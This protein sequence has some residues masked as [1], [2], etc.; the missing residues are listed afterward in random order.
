MARKIKDVDVSGSVSFRETPSTS[1]S[2]KGSGDFS[3]P[4]STQSGSTTPAFSEK[5]KVSETMRKANSNYWTPKQDA[6]K[7]AAD[8]YQ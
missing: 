2:I 5:N 8:A 6:A 4:A 3:K 1:T 7:K